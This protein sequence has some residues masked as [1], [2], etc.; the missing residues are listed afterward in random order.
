MPGRACTFT[1]M[2]AAAQRRAP[3][4]RKKPV[5]GPDQDVVLLIPGWVTAWGWV[6]LALTGLVLALISYAIGARNGAASGWTVFLSVSVTGTALGTWDYLR[7]LRS[8][9]ARRERDLCERSEFPRLDAMTWRE[10]EYYCADLLT[11]L[12]YSDVE[13]IGS[14]PDEGGLDILATSP[15]DTPVGVQVK[16]RKPNPETGRPVPLGPDKVRELFGA[17]AGRRYAGRLGIL[18]TNTYVQPAGRQFAREN[19]ITILDRRE[20]LD[21]WMNQA[22]NKATA[23]AGAPRQMHP[24]TRV[25]LGIVGAAAIAVL[26]VTVSAQVAGPRPAPV[27]APQAARA[28]ATAATSP[29]SP[30][31]PSASPERPVQVVREFY[32]AVNNHDWPRVWQLG[33]RNLGQGPYATYDGMITGYQGTIRD[34]LT[35]IRATGDTVTGRFVAYQS[36]GVTRPYLFTY[37]VRNGVIVSGRQQQG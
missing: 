31:T 21:D 26:T 18:M 6:P 37:V 34:V 19:G 33:G 10:I 24:E 23:A 1:P 12:G 16:H 30:G 11:A 22:R 36:G 13:V 17:V 5:N 28:A 9:Q 25:M 4:P 35:E 27:A 7:R 8:R 14:R 20:G 29:R 3:A 2:T 32:A 15:D